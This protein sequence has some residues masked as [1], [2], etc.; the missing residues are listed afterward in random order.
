MRRVTIVPPGIAGKAYAWLE[1]GFRRGGGGGGQFGVGMWG[2]RRMEKGEGLI[3]GVGEK[4]EERRRRRKL[5]GP[6]AFSRLRMAR[7]GW[8]ATL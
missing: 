5:T 7:R 8:L 4:R 3:K 6:F 2:W 1:V